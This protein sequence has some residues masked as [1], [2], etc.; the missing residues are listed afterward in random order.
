MQMLEIPK[1]SHVI[2]KNICKPQPNFG[3]DSLLSYLQVIP[4]E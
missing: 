1:P 3:I 4:A 2:S